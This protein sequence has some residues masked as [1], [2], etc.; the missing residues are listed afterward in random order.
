MLSADLEPFF[1]LLAELYTN[2]SN[3]HYKW[4]ASWY[5]VEGHVTIWPKVELEISLD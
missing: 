5:T 2:K 3:Y 1:K 4:P